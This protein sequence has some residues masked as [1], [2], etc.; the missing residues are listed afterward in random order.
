VVL[1]GA[2]TAIAT[3]EGEVH[4]NSTGNPGLSTGGTGDVLTGVITA[5][6]AQGYDPVEA[7][8][9]GVYSHGLAGDRAAA[10]HGQIGL[11]ASDVIENLRWSL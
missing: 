10:E 4:F 9:L 7:S 11:T 8:V 1:K 3:P 6:L 2:N 5:L